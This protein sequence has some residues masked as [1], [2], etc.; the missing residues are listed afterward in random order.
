MKEMN[1]RWKRLKDSDSRVL[2][3]RTP[4]FSQV[5]LNEVCRARASKYRGLSRDTG[6][7]ALGQALSANS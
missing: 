3:F 1:L 7:A 2:R 5:F 4:K 6:Q